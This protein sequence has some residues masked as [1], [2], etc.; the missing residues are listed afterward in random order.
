MLMLR[1]PFHRT[2]YISALRALYWLLQRPSMKFTTLLKQPAMELD[3][4]TKTD[5]KMKSM[6]KPKPT[7]TTTTMKC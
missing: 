2:D 1:A 6:H 7:T 4:K 3:P 5:H